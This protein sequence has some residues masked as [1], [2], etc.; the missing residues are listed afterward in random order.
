M[1]VPHQTRHSRSSPNSQ[2]LVSCSGI[3]TDYDETFAKVIKWVT[4]GASVALTA[5]NRWD[6]HHMDVCTTFLHGVLKE[7]V[8][9]RQ[10]PSFEAPGQEHKVCKLL[11]SL[12]GLKQLPRA[13]YDKIDLELRRIGLL[14]SPLDPNLYYLHQDNE[15]LI[16]MLYVDNLFITGSSSRLID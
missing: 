13:W 1:G 6:I 12:Y 15:I 16:V 3:R 9:M 10:P 5:T 4:I 2:G 11:R 8:Y 14:R 7:Q